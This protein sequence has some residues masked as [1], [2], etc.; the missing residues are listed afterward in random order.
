MFIFD[1]PFSLV[2]DFICITLAVVLLSISVFT[3]EIIITSLI[4]VR[5]HMS[6]YI[7][8][9]NI[10]AIVARVRHAWIALSIDIMIM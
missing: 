3:V 2:C 6:V 7:K 5:M 8:I 10:I 4:H 1:L 9:N